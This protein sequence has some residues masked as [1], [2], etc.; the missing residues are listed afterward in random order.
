MIPPNILND[1]KSIW[2]TFLNI[3]SPVKKNSREMKNEIRVALNIT[4]EKF[5]NVRSFLTGSR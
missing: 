3:R 5:L 2:K 4:L 1:S